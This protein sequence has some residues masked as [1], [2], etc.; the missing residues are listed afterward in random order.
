M[1]AKFDIS[2]LC[3]LGSSRG[4][5]L[6]PKLG[7]IDPNWDKSGTY[8]DQISVHFVSFLPIKFQCIMALAK[9]Y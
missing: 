7:E 1:D 4:V 8:T 5:R 2:A 3:V 6:G 9:M